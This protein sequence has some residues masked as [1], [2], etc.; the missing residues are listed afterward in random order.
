MYPVDVN[1]GTSPLSRQCVRLLYYIVRLYR[2][3][4]RTNIIIN[5]QSEQQKGLKYNNMLLLLLLSAARLRTVETVGNWRKIR[6]VIHGGKVATRKTPL[7]PK[8]V[9]ARVYRC[10]MQKN[11]THH[12]P[13]ALIR[14]CN[15]LYENRSAPGRHR[16]SMYN[17]T[18]IQ[19]YDNILAGDNDNVKIIW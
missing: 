15:P 17:M 7:E 10:C 12:S 19:I 3:Y 16:H 1:G 5:G 8:G 4:F 13:S 14:T 6:P 9:T 2:H 11:Q 18:L